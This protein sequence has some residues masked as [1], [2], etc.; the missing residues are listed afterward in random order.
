MYTRFRDEGKTY[1]NTFRGHGKIVK[2]EELSRRLCFD[3]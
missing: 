1:R 2:Y 3:S